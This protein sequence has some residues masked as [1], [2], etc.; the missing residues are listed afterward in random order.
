M[1]RIRRPWTIQRRD[2]EGVQLNALDTR[3]KNLE[4]NEHGMAE[5]TGAQDTTQPIDLQQGHLQEIEVDIQ[6]VLKDDELKDIEEDT[7]PYAEVRAVVPETDDPSWS[8]ATHLIQTSGADPNHFSNTSEH[9]EDVDTW[10][11]R[12]SRAWYSPMPTL[13]SLYKTM[14]FMLT[15]RL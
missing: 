4:A 12:L 14:A 3:G 6:N 9:A 15:V 2:T 5:K 13:P 1:N 7:S 11:V 10:D 8:S